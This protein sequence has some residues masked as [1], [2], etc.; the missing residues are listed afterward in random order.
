[1]KP[2]QRILCVDDEPDIRAVLGQALEM[3]FGGEVETVSSGAEA[4]SYLDCHPC[5]DLII[6]DSMMPDMDGYEVC[7]RLRAD[8]RYSRVPIVFL[9][10]WTRQSE[11]TR[12]LDAGA[13][14][15]LTKPFDPLAV[16]EQILTE[17]AA[18]R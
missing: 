16:G 12:A 8:A 14:A 3:A 5:P 10:A 7:M 6:L 4:F 13:T 9:T 1:M 18:A 11:L 15:C 2:P 17:L